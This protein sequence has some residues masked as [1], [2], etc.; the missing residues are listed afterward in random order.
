MSESSK[1]PVIN[2]IIRTAEA[3]DVTAEAFHSHSHGHSHD[4]DHD[5]NH[6]H[7]HS[8]GGLSHFHSHRNIIGFDEHG[9]PTVILKGDHHGENESEDDS[10]EFIKDYTKAVNEYR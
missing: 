7:D 9:I 5:H 2:G 6:P 3:G 10:L 4:H 8:H 1:T